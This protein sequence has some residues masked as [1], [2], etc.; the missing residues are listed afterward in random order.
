MAQVVPT[1]SHRLQHAPRFEIS[2]AGAESNVAV[3]LARL[4]TPA[5]WAGR[6]GDDPLG[7]RV[8]ESLLG[9]GVDTR[10][11]VWDRTR[12]T[13]VFFKDPS[14]DGSRV[15]YYRVGSAASA[16]TS[17]DIES[18]LATHPRWV[19]LSGVTSALSAS[20]SQTVL[21]TLAAAPQAGA[22]TSFDVNYRPALWPN[23]DEAARHL[24]VA[25]EAADVVFVGMDEAATL[26][27]VHDAEGVRRHIEGPR[28][29]V[30]KD[31]AREAV[32]FDGWTTTRVAAPPVQVTEPVGAGDSFAAG[33]IHGML[34]GMAPDA[35]LRLGHML[36]AIALAT[37]ADHQDL[38]CPPEDLEGRARTGVGWTTLA[39]EL[40]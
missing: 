12:P 4:G 31:G 40:A 23:P 24:K 33:W 8:D 6:L 27:P 21:E 26:W 5:L 10:H 15:F 16:M 7:H 37:R 34:H 19:H 2:A 22:R 38:P 36:A 11:V 28:V 25:A 35:C 9:A 3:T 20:C 1:D 29:L 32:A 14:P 30:V 17:L 18:A 13:G 39:K